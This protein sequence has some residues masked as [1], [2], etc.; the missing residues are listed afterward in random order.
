[1][2]MQVSDP[3]NTLAF[4]LGAAIA[5]DL[6]AREYEHRGEMRSM[7]PRRDTVDVVLFAQ[8]WSST[9]LGFDVGMAGQAFCSAY[10]VVV[11][12]ERTACVYFAEGLAYSVDTRNPAFI[13][14]LKNRNLA[15]QIE[16]AKRYG[17]TLPARRAF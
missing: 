5:S 1:M 6:P 8:D 17:A 15:G 14:D 12:F 2:I 13:E 11:S 3:L 10:T 9:A 16:A 4:A 7:R